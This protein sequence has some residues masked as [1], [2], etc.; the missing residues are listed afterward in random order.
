MLQAAQASALPNSSSGATGQAM[1]SSFVV[2]QR[3]HC[4]RVLHFAFMMLQ[5]CSR[6]TSSARASATISASAN[7]RYA[8]CLVRCRSAVL[9]SLASELRSVALSD[10]PSLSPYRALLR[11]QYGALLADLKHTCLQSA[12]GG[13]GTTA[14]NS[15]V[16]S[17]VDEVVRLRSRVL[18]GLLWGVVSLI[19]V[20]HRP[21]VE[22]E[23]AESGVDNGNKNDS[24][25]TNDNTGRATSPA[26]VV[27]VQLLRAL[28]AVDLAALAPSDRQP[29]HS[30]GSGYSSSGSSDS[31]F[32]TIKGDC[33]GAE[34]VLLALIKLYH[35]LRM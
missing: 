10:H 23:E 8:L 3:R 22:G 1:S 20:D 32:G 35:D 4:I 30:T 15:N 26:C 14:I 24:D 18:D 25:N 17:S 33:S 31:A 5:A 11:A 6:C 7:L 34:A 19:A 2:H 27:L 16:D 12:A 28:R 9:A 13:S 29:H 21:V